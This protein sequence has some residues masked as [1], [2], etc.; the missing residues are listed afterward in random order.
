M[1]K[2]RFVLVWGNHVVAFAAKQHI[3]YFSHLYDG[4]V[5]NFR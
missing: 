4:G 2:E 3:S 1:K 5:P